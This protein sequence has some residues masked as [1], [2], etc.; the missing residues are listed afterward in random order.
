MENSARI[1]D[2]GRGPEIEGTRVTV[3]VVL[4]YL[5]AGRPRDWI[6]TNLR[7]SLS[8]I[9][10]AIDYIEENQDQ[11]EAVYAKARERIEQGNP[12]WVDQR[13]NANRSKFDALVE[14]CREKN[15]SSAAEQNAQNHVRQ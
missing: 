1:I 9:Q 10:A 11:V 5:R 12:S 14:S 2:R 7:L 3:H 4:E 8:Q 6:A 15:G 13:L